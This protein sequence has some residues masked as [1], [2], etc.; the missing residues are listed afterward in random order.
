MRRL[1]RRTCGWA[2]F[3]VVALPV[4]SAV[5]LGGP[6]SALVIGNDAY[7]SPWDLNSC[8]NDA[9][10]FAGWLVTV[11]YEKDEVKVITNANKT[12]MLS[13]FENLARATEQRRHDQVVI[14]YSG[15]GSTMKDDDG[16]E[17]PNDG[18]DEVL[19]AIDNPG[20]AASPDKYVIRDD[21]FHRLVQRI[22]ANTDQV[23]VVFDC[24][25]SGGAMKSVAGAVPK[26]ARKRIPE[27][28]LYRTLAAAGG[29][30]KGLRATP[31][32]RAKSLPANIAAKNGLAELRWPKSAK[33][34]VFFSAASEFEEA[35]AAR[36]GESLSVFTAAFL[37][38]V[39][40]KA[41]K[42]AQDVS[43][44]DLHGRLVEHL[45]GTQTPLLKTEGIATSTAFAPHVFP[46]AKQIEQQRR[47]AMILERLMFL[48][49]VAQGSAWKVEAR[50]NPPAPVKVGS[51]Y[52]LR[53]RPSQAGRLVVFT[54]EADGEVTFFY[55]NRFTPDNSVKAGEEVPI[56]W[57]G[58]LRADPPAGEEQFYVYLIERDPFQGFDFRECEG[59]LLV[60]KIDDV[61]RR[62][63]K[64]N[65][66]EEFRS[67]LAR[68]PQQAAG[69]TA[70]GTTQWTRAV[71]TVQTTR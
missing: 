25:F 49:R 35:S 71:V 62:Y 15:H 51:H 10:A 14:Y 11:G 4:F 65:S 42:P 24:C 53:V 26:G 46:P 34:L 63:S 69:Q 67:L 55:P 61:V 27:A 21:E 41:G 31:P 8:V 39:R 37:D 44:R 38:A 47:F 60:G 22:S 45:R 28:D 48:P 33:S 2:C 30:T 32:S 56:P 3:L 43:L 68:G 29:S 1:P 6:R 54:V 40:P 5:C 52:E 58:A 13:G 66:V 16:D 59:E 70:T 7:P 19:V 9:R 64:I 23:V 36:P 57:A 17:G 50:C 12:A 18:T 20:D